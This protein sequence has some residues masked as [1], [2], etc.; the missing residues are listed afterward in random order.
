[1]KIRE[2]VQEIID[3]R[4]GQGKYQGNG[5]LVTIQQKLAFVEQL[6]KDV[7]AFEV[8]LNQIKSDIQ[9]SNGKFA[10]LVEK[11]PQFANRLLEIN[12]HELK[13]KIAVQKNELHRLQNRF[14]RDSVQIAFIGQAR[15]G[16]SSFLQRISGLNEDTIPSSSAT[17][18]TGAISIISNYEG[19]KK[20]FFE[21]EI[22]YYSVL[23]F[24]AA[25]NNK[26]LQ[27]FP[28]S[29]LSISSLHEIP[30]LA[31]RHEFQN[32]ED[33]EV[34]NFKETYID[35]FDI[36]SSLIGHANEVKTDEKV[37]AELVAKY[38]MYKSEKDIPADY[39]IYKTEKKQHSGEVQ[40]FFC[41]Y[42]AVKV[43]YITKKF[44]YADAGNIVLVDTIG[45]GNAP[46][47]AEDKAKM[48]DVLKNE[49]DAAVYIY[50]PS[51]DGASKNPKA[52]SALL[53]DLHCELCDYEPEKWLVGVINKKA[54]DK[55]AKKG[56]EYM[57]YLDYLESIK[58]TFS[59]EKVLAW[60][61]IVDAMSEQEVTNK[62]LI[63]LLQTIIGNIDAID[64]SFMLKADAH[65]EALYQSYM[66]ICG[67]VNMLSALFV[68]NENK[69]AIFDHEYDN[70]LLKGQLR[71]Y[72]DALYAHISEPSLQMIDDLTPFVEDVI[73]Y[74]PKANE[75]EN[76]LNQG[77]QYA[78]SE[79][80][81]SL[82]MDNIRSQILSSIKQ[83]SSR[84]VKTIQ[85]KVQDD[86]IRLLFDAGAL[87]QI[88][89]KSVSSNM[90]T[91]EWFIA[92]IAEKLKLYPTLSSAF[93]T[94]ADFEMRIEGFL[95]SKCICACEMLRPEKTKLP[96]LEEGSTIE[97]KAIIIQ[98]ALYAVI[99]EVQQKLYIE[100]GLPIPQ[101][102]LSADTTPIEEISQPNLIMW[103]MADTFQQEIRNGQ[104]A[105]ELEDFYWENANAIWHELIVKG[106][107]MHE[108]ATEWNAWED[109]LETLCELNNFKIIN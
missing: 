49:S 12:L 9:Q 15:Q 83:V 47:E 88:K 8:F 90:P 37:V 98:Q 28:Q 68:T 6:E 85:S 64:S 99:L 34:R 63:P 51:E 7:N 39:K 101:G 35:C 65:A 4:K 2:Q 59:A 24:V 61:E 27:L 102:L 41:K 82:Y 73:N 80:V 20:N 43:A 71:A 81:Y 74:I 1:M 13:Q 66:E 45:L 72:V 77:G 57:T 48:F 75:I 52:E 84:S 26:L 93:Q 29:H 94:V 16:K 30:S 56:N 105:K 106:E 21:V 96:A 70:L 78:W 10:D 50:K 97:D 95:Y 25:V 76:K 107:Q 23:E 31:H 3:S 109:C 33:D 36:Y 67:K 100:L 38:K 55:C 62:L 108:A 91:K 54:E 42:V 11:Q 22:E 5:R 92:L 53:N 46:T 89:L 60:C 19:S 69:K 104:G 17:D 40:V 86:I 79:N 18:C 58:H 32:L 103:C 44:P 87:K 14:S